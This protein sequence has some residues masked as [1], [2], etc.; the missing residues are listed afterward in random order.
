MW[1]K[2]SISSLMGVPYDYPDI[3]P[4]KPTE[5]VRRV[6]DPVDPALAIE[7]QRIVEIQRNSYQ[8]FAPILSPS[9]PAVQAVTFRNRFEPSAALEA[10]RRARAARALMADA[11]VEPR[12]EP[13]AISAPQIELPAIERWRRAIRAEEQLAPVMRRSAIA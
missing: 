8:S 12:R 9:D 6:V 5:A 10:E 11:P 2:K 1:L 4:V 7:E 3:A 13:L